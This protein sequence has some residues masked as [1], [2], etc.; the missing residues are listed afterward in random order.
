MCKVEHGFLAHLCPTIPPPEVGPSGAVKSGVCLEQA[1]RGEPLPSKSPPPCSPGGKGGEVCTH[2]HFP[3]IA[4]HPSE[5]RRNVSCKRHRIWNNREEKN[6]LPHMIF[7][8]ESC[9]RK[10]TKTLPIP[11]QFFERISL[12][13]LLMLLTKK[14]PHEM[15]RIFF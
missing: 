4:I 2:S 8:A 12:F 7:H 3:P 10:F 13:I 6:L 14:F 9:P 15:K 11:H 5:S 1:R